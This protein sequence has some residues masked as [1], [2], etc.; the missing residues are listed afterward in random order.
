MHRIAPPLVFLRT[1]LTA[2]AVACTAAAALGQTVTFPEP[3]RDRWMYPFNATPGFRTIAPTFG[4]PL[5]VGFDD[6]DGQLIVGYDTVGQIDPGQGPGSYQV[7]A[8]TLVATISTDNAFRYDPTFDP[9]EWIID[10]SLDQDEGHP[11]YLLGVGYRSGFTL[12]TWEEDSPYAVEPPVVPPAQGHRTAYPTDLAGDAARDV[13]NYLKE[14]FEFT[15]WAIG[16]CDL[17]SGELV[18]IETEFTF[19]VDLSNA[20]ALAYVQESL[21][22]GRLNFAIVAPHSAVDGATDYPS[23]FTREAGFGAVRLEIELGGD[24]PGD[25]NGDGV[26]DQSDLGL[27]LAAYNFCDG[28]ANWNADADL[29]GDGCVGQTDLGILLANYD[30]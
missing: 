30:G 20:E 4:A 24:V 26:V 15:P 19:A 21:D 2:T 27:L 11:A 6:L 8:V 1:G 16:T 5:V 23:Y 3:D 29:D 17:A 22:R 18:P 28:D 7:S 12:E 9:N 14:E 10:E 25:V 13:S